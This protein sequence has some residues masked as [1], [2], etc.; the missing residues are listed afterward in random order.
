MLFFNECD[1]FSLDFFIKYENV[2]LIFK[3]HLHC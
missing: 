3:I 2:L 1:L